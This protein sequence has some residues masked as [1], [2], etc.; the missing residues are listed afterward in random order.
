MKR[1]KTQMRILSLAV[2]LLFCISIIP[3]ALAVGVAELPESDQE[4][5]LAFWQQEA[6]DGMNNGEAVYAYDFMEGSQHPSPVY[7]GGYLTALIF[8]QYVSGGHYGYD[9]NFVYTLPWSIVFNGECADGMLDIF[10]DLYGSLDLAGTGLI[11][12]GAGQ[13]YDHP[14]QT[15][16]PGQTH[17]TSVTL[18]GCDLLRTAKFS[19]QEYCGIFSALDC[20]QLSKVELLDGAFRRID[21]GTELYEKTVGAAAFGS[22]SVGMAFDAENGEGITLAAYPENDIFIGWFDGGELVSRELECTVTDGGSYRAVFAG[23]ADGDGALTISD[24]VLV[25]RMS[26][27]LLDTENYADVNGNGSVDVSDAIMILR[28]AMGIF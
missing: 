1:S 8:E 26:M 4:K 13:A 14:F 12:L 23:D 2:A 27:N 11:N 5:L 7:Q 22:G 9:F 16:L 21:V 28:F 6:Y 10:P 19:G 25:L 15:I 18:D 3:S 20:P 24:A 17:I